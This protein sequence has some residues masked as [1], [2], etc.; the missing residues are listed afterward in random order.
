MCDCSKT[1]YNIFM[2]NQ[3][4]NVLV[5]QLKEEKTYIICALPVE[6]NE[7]KGIFYSG[8]GKV[9]AVIKTMEIIHVHKAKKIINYG[10]CGALNNKVNGV[11]KINKIQKHAID[12]SPIGYEKRLTPFDDIQEI[13]SPN[14][15]EY[16]CATGDYFV[17]DN[18]SINADVVDMEA[19]A[20]AKTCKISNIQFECFKYISDNAD[21]DAP[22]NWEKNCSKGFMIFMKQLK[23]LN[24]I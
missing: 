9:N 10:S 6:A 15:H 11:V 7:T 22:E 20:I 4:I 19:Y 24:R 14:D 2:N 12:C 8:L 3:D 21:N 16:T 5:D 23:K 1:C 18:Q 13:I 17:S